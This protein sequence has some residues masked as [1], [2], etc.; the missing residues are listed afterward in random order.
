[1]PGASTF[2]VQASSYFNSKQFN[3]LLL[4]QVLVYNRIPKAGSGSMN[5]FLGEAE[6]RGGFYLCKSKLFHDRLLT[7]AA[8]EVGLQKWLCISTE[9]IL[10][11]CADRRVEEVFVC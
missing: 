9:E 6:P 8:A 4:S 7:G 10:A 2:V 5:I 3:L 11:F 1:M